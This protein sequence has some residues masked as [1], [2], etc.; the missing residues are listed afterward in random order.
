[1][2]NKSKTDSVASPQFIMDWTRA[3]FGTFFDP[4][5]LIE[6]WDPDKH[7]NGLAIEWG[8]VNYVNPPFSKACRFVKKAYEEYAKNKVIVLL[9]KTELTGRKTF[10]GLCDIVFFRKPVC[11]PKYKGKAPPFVCC[12]LVFH[13][14]SANNFYFFEE[15]SGKEFN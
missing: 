9:C 10:K 4:C 2:F 5:P 6:N 13:P 15:L 14:R 7:T 12:L 1:M 8:A 3:T 11:F